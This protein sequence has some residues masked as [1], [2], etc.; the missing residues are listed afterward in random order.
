LFLIFQDPGEF[1]LRPLE[2]RGEKGRISGVEWDRELL[3]EGQCVAA[4][5]KN[6]KPAV[7]KGVE[8]CDLVGERVTRDGSARFWKD[9]FKIYYQGKL[10]D[11]CRPDKDG[12]TFFID[13]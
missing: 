7:P 8:D 9:P 2:L 5:K 11:E 1:P 10:I 3:K 4:W 13:K 12:C 6:G